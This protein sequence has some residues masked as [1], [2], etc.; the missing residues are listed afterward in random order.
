MASTDSR[1]ARATEA[2]RPTGRPTECTPERYAAYLE[3]LR[4]G[5][6][7]EYAAARGGLA[8]QTVLDW[9]ARGE[10]GEEPFAAFAEA[11]Q[12]AI[13]DFAAQHLQAIADA[14]AKTFVT[15]AW[16]L[17]RRLNGHFAQRQDVTISGDS[18]R[19]LH[20]VADAA[21]LPADALAAEL[22]RRQAA[23][24]STLSQA[25]PDAEGDSEGTD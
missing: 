4:I 11:H 22:A 18:D 20:V 23:Q 25:T 19:P 2:P 15:H 5:L 8:Y 13:A 12:R 24:A 3:G 7:I 6:P 21:S 14:D 9:R 16:L 1:E 17:E 10:N